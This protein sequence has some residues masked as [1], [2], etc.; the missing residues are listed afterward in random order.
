MI[1]PSIQACR[2]YKDNGLC[3]DSCPK[4]TFY[5]HSKQKLID[6]PPKYSFNRQCV[7]KCPGLSTTYLLTYGNKISPKYVSALCIGTLHCMSLLSL[8]ID[9]ISYCSLTG[10]LKP[11]CFLVWMIF[12]SSEITFVVYWQNC[13]NKYVHIFIL[14]LLLTFLIYYYA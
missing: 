8:L 9:R 3:R 1:H 11:V 5:D 12:F 10:Q 6:L 14:N 7:D 13:H 2:N 4:D